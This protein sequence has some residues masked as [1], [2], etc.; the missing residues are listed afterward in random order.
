V[1]SI[2]Q[3]KEEFAHVDV[4]KDTTM[5]ELNTIMARYPKTNDVKG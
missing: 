5:E 4:G 3:V 1:S 2:T